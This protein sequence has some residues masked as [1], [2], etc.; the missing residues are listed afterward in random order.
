[1]NLLRE[2]IRRL[3]A[4]KT[5]A[6]FGV[7]KGQWVDVSPEDL[8]MRSQETGLDDEVFD[9][10]TTAYAS[11]PGGNV[12]IQ[13]AQDIPGKYTFFDAVDIDADPEPDAVVF[14]KTRGGALKVGG[15][16]HDGGA[17]KRVSVSRFIE[18]LKR[19]GTFAEVSGR[20]AQIAMAAG[21]TIIE[22]EAKVRGLVQ[23]DLEWVGERSGSEGRG[24]YK[25]Q[26]G[27]GATHLKTLVGTV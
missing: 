18:L 6:D 27:D 9:L 2:Y 10:V 20:I 21:V 13:S 22:D 1:M 8:A 14:G 24:W 17:G 23:R 19:P 12:K 16:G 7:P 3:L 15:L 26:Y 11:L 25:R 4:E 5:F